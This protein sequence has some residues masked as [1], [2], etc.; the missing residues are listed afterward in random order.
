MAGGV[1]GS[2]SLKVDIQSD[3]PDTVAV[4][5]VGT[6]VAKTATVSF[7]YRPIASSAADKHLVKRMTR[8]GS[9]SGSAQRIK[10]YLFWVL[11]KS[12]GQCCTHHKV[13]C[14]KDVKTQ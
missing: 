6:W 13:A 3:D 5:A 1:G 2:G 8:N 7:S 12:K 4:G 11:S 14:A 10:G 9:T